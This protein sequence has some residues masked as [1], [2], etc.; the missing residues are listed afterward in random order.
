MMKNNGKEKGH[1]SGK[2]KNENTKERE[3]EK[4]L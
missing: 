2:K 3:H 1:P 4:Y